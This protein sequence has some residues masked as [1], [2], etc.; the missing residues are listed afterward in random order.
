MH[1]TN[2]KLKK[3]EKK[4]LIGRANRVISPGYRSK[5]PFL[6]KDQ[7]VKLLARGHQSENVHLDF[8]YWIVKES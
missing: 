4:N 3:K 8:Q 2:K 1:Q 7:Y 6:K 5:K